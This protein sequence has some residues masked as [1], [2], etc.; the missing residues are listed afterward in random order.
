MF[1]D[2]LECGKWNG[3]FR[4]QIDEQWRYVIIIFAFSFFALWILFAVLWY[5]IAHAH[6]DLD[7]DPVT[8]ERLS[9]GP[10]PCVQGCHNFA[11]FLLFSIETQVSYIP[12][13]SELHNGPFL[14][15]GIH[16]L[17]QQISQRRMP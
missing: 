2:D 13:D 17:R 14:I 3:N 5:L 7:F 1:C 12:K 6:G 4:F 10:V 8:G 11:A 16:W 15:V 9:D